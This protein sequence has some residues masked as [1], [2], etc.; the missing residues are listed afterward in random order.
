MA[1]NVLLSNLIQGVPALIEQEILLRVLAEVLEV[2]LGLTLLYMTLKG[3]T[4]W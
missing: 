2:I 1:E 4:S 3:V